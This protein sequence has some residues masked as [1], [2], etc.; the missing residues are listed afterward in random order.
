MGII[1]ETAEMSDTERMAARNSNTQYLKNRLHPVESGKDG[2]WEWR[3][4]SDGTAECWGHYTASGVNAA[5]NN[6]SG[7][8]Y[9]DILEISLPCDFLSI[10]DYQVNGGSADRVNFAREYGVSSDNK[11][12]GFRICGHQS[13][14]T[15][16]DISVYVSVKGRWKAESGGSE[17]GEEDEPTADLKYDPTSKNAQSGLAVAEAVAIEQNR[18]NA[19]FSNALKGSKSGSALLID[20]VSPISHDIGV[21]I[22]GKNLCDDNKRLFT[23]GGIFFGF[24][25][26]I[27][28]IKLS[29]GTY[30]FSVVTADGTTTNLYIKNSDNTK[31]LFAAYSR[32]K[33]TFTL[34]ETQDI[35]L[36]V[37]KSGYTSTDDV[38][39][40]Q[41]E[42]GTTATAYTP[43]VPDL[44]A[45]KVSR[46]GKNL[47]DIN[48]FINLTGNSTY[49]GINDNGELYVK[50]SDYRD[51]TV[52]PVFITLEAGTYTL[53]STTAITS[54]F[55][56]INLTDNK[57]IA[58]NN[59]I[60]FSIEKATS[61]GIKCYQSADT[62]I[63][64]LQLELGSTATDYE[65][66]KEC[67]EYTPATDGTVNGVTS[68]YPNTT[69]MTDTEGV[70]IDCEY[71]RDIN[72]AFAELQQAIISSG[73]NV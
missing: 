11:K 21:K 14:A 49:Y 43:Y 73:G 27:I 65:P 10:K 45:V 70:L 58:F 54:S 56:L 20:D 19:T 67:E 6:F 17:S 33:L 62:V 72:K 15:S 38:V 18:A 60:T 16:V 44:T 57:V 26:S 68:L 32:N 41:L 22:R 40:A 12:V 39:T 2:I 51:D 31:T 3:K 8:Y 30:T 1:R 42:I 35:L 13:E 55:K 29:K 23:G 69:L 66:Y 47:F 52:I 34:S 46:C 5:K 28:P 48:G 71:N 24:T 53:S 59:N 25:Q 64:K 50:Q 7:Y 4:W 37:Y 36:S 61:L 9:S 63:G